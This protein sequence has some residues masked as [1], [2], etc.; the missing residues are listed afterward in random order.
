MCFHMHTDDYIYIHYILNVIV[1]EQK[2]IPILPVN[3]I[4]K[5][6]PRKQVKNIIAEYTLKSL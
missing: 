2:L 3:I 4:L 6:A 1:K 5:E